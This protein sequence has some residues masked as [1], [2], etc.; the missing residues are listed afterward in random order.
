MRCLFLPPDPEAFQEIEELV[1][2]IDHLRELHLNTPEKNE[3]AK[4]HNEKQLELRKQIA[5]K[6]KNLLEKKG[7]VKSPSHKVNESNEKDNIESLQRKVIV[8]INARLV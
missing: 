3:R 4:V 7:S 6:I 1:K 2:K 8:E 5:D